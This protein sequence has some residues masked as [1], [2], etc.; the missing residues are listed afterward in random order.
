MSGHRDK[1][2]LALTITLSIMLVCLLASY[3]SNAITA[4]SYH[5][6]AT[7]EFTCQPNSNYP[8]AVSA[9]VDL[10]DGMTKTEAALIAT[11]VFAHEMTNAKFTLKSATVDD[12]GIWTVKFSW[13]IGQ[14]SLSHY[15]NVEINPFNQTAAYSRYY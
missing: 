3:L 11:K 5:D 6:Y 1:I 13:G 9:Y 2:I 12:T 14:E 4:N 10:E 15:F 7:K 8:F